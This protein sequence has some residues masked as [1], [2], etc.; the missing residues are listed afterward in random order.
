MFLATDYMT[1]INPHTVVIV[2]LVVVLT[3]APV[4]LP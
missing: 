3:P 1:C 2:F 4:R